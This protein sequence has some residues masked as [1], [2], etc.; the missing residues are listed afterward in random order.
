MDEAPLPIID[1]DTLSH[2]GYGRCIYCGSR[3]GEDGLHEEHVLQFS[4]GGNATIKKGSCSKCEKIT[5][6]LDGFLANH[7]FNEVRISRRIQSRS[8][9]TKKTKE[10]PFTYALNKGPRTT[11]SLRIEDRPYQVIFPS[12]QPP[13]VLSASKPVTTF[14]NFGSYTYTHIP[15]TFWDTVGAGQEGDI[16]IVNKKSIDLH[17]FCRALA[18][19][20][21]GYQ[22]LTSG[23][24]EYARSE[25][26]DLVRGLY[27][28][29]SH[30]VGGDGLPNAKA[31]EALHA[32]GF[33]HVAANGRFYQF[34]TIRL[35]AN[36]KDP[37]GIG[38]PTYRVMMGEVSYD[39]ILVTR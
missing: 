5:C 27:P 18:K 9:T 20:A 23:A 21:V 16:E 1:A 26:N 33:D 19:I 11:Q 39:R 37:N 35:F 14:S 17:T 7:I 30:I 36:C 28:Y 38:P 13:G 8:G 2:E 31:V 10:L 15:E 4:L 34:C 22:A 6:K 24:S 25:A 12:L 32:I 29:S 3:G